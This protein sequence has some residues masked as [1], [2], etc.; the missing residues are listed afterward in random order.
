MTFQELQDKY[1]GKRVMTYS[2]DME[3]PGLVIGVSGP[4]APTLTVRLDG[5]NDEVTFHPKQ[6]RILKKKQKNTIWVAYPSNIS[7]FP[8]VFHF[9]PETK[10]DNGGMYF[11]HGNNGWIHIK[12]LVQYSEMNTNVL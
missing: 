5:S 4:K 8:Y 10:V 6:T 12:H 3:A 7:I 9:K 11:R 1:M 2:D